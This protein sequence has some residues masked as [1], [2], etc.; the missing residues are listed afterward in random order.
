MIMPCICPL[1]NMLHGIPVFS[2]IAFSL[3]PILLVTLLWF[4]EVVNVVE[5]VGLTTVVG[6]PRGGKV[7]RCAGVSAS[8]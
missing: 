7:W 5:V 6:R 4:E 1:S 3:L 8:S 2:C